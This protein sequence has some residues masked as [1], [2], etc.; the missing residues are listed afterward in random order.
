MTTTPTAP[1]TRVLTQ[2]EQIDALGRYQFGWSDSDDKG[3]L[4]RR[5]LSEDVVRN[6]SALK[7]E[8]EWMLE[9]GQE[10]V[11]RRWQ[12]Y[13]EMAMRSADRFAA[14]ARP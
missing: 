8:P 10:Q 6:I 14:D 11:N 12:E 3:A 2:D 1:E 4:A 5:G 9:H 7:N 13:E